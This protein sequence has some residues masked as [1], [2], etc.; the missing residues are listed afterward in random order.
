MKISDK[1]KKTLRELAA[2][3]K[4]YSQTQEAASRRSQALA[5]GNLRGGKPMVHAEPEGAWRE[6]LPVTSLTCK[7]PLLQ[8][9]EMQLR[10][11]IYHYENIQD[12]HFFPAVLEVPWQINT[13]GYG[14]ILEEEHSREN[15]GAYAI[16]PAI[17]D[18]HTDID[19]LHFRTLEVDRD[20]TQNLV[21][22]AQELL[23]D[24]V[25]IKIKGLYWWSTGLT[26]ECIKLIGL[27]QFMMKMIDDAAGIHQLM[28]FLRDEML[29]FITWH[30]QENLLAGNNGDV[31]GGSGGSC[32]ASALPEPD[33]KTSDVKL[34]DMWGFSESQ[35]TVGVSPQMFSQFILPYQKPIMQ[36]FGLLYYGCC[37]GLEKRIKYLKDIPGLRALSVAPWCDQETLLQEGGKNYLYMRKP[38][39]SLVLAD[40]WEDNVRQDISKTLKIFKGCNLQFILKDT[41]TIN[42]EPQRFNRWVSIVREEIAKDS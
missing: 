9:W 17:S 16:K 8:G 14:M 23:G 41:H 37:E 34:Q 18:I 31:Y 12:D 13:G 36:K 3:I 35:E 29:H 21:H 20:K 2:K 1:E 6:I 7:D 5:L 27:Q 11:K 33:K 10:Q 19:K 39:P 25:K 24:L 26:R 38:N 32:Y 15:R 22:F 4:A 42:N 28:A 30:E 40:N